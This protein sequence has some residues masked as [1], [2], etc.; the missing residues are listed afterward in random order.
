MIENLKLYFLIC[1]TRHLA[2][3]FN[4]FYPWIL[5][6][7]GP[8]SAYIFVYLRSSVDVLFYH[9]NLDAQE[10]VFPFIL[11][12]EQGFFGWRFHQELLL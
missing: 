12:T 2:S 3:H 4:R 9:I 7:V 1:V 8:V 10:T 6:A 5:M 11:I